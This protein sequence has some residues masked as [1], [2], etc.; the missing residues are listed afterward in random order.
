MIFRK[1]EPSELDTAYSIHCETVDWLLAKGVRQWTR[2]VPKDIFESRQKQ[3][4]LF[5]LDTDKTIVAVVSI[6]IRSSGNWEN[7]LGPGKFLFL[8]TLSTGNAF[9][10]KEYG[11]FLL[12]MTIQH[13]E[14]E[15][16][17]DEIYLDCV[18]GSGFLP[19]FY[20]TFGFID[21][22]RKNIEYPSGIFDMLLM[23]RKVNRPS[24]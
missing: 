7:E 11:K 16:T 18:V 12:E 8:S 6:A 10:G 3:N 21:V 20:R 2:P 22:A 9:R 19:N 17:K 14:V 1:V 5:C 24:T 23:K 4:E 13:I 15:P